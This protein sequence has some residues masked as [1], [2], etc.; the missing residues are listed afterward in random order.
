MVMSFDG[1]VISVGSPGLDFIFDPIVADLRQHTREV[2][3]Y[4]D[5]PQFERQSATVLPRASV[6]VAVSS[7][8][9]TREL[10]VRA[11]ELRAV[12]S[13]F[14][15]TEGFDE[16]AA[17]ALGII[18]ANG[19]VAENFLSMAESTILLVLASLYSLHWWEQQLR[20]N[21]PHPPRVPGR[22]LH[23]RT[24]GMI[25]FGHIARAIADRL[26]PWGVRLQTYVPRLRLA[27]PDQVTR[28]ELD[29]LL[30]TSD[31]VCV[32]ASLNAETRGLLDL[33]RLRLMK[34]DAVLVNTA[35]GGIINEQALVQVARERPALRI[36]LDTFAEEPLPIDSP[37]RSLPNGILT[38]HA[39]G[40]TREALAALHP[41]AV[42]NV[43]R[44][45]G[46]DLPLHVR[47]PE[48]IPQWTRRW[49][50]KR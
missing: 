48:V 19:Q 29:E 39:I 5:Y 2:V 12:V 50:E 30:A 14:I 20:E 8:P 11:P 40:H 7:F 13:P 46:G 37:L 32:L 21:A 4:T 33:R 23:G 24:V 49:S 9:C 47:N 3:Q 36:A 44:V 27:L 26:H 42:E 17:T 38:P 6:L 25:G 34:P 1:T 15:G 43:L 28:V 10:M 45:L 16:G 31:V 41:A 18:V 35:R 22:M